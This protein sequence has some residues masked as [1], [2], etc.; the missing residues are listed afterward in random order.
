M[1]IASWA[2]QSIAQSSSFRRSTCQS[3]RSRHC[4]G[5]APNRSAFSARS[6]TGE[7]GQR[8]SELRVWIDP[9]HNAVLTSEQGLDLVPSRG[10][11]NTPILPVYPPAADDLPAARFARAA[12]ARNPQRS[13]LVVDEVRSLTADIRSSTTLEPGEYRSRDPADHVLLAPDTYLLVRRASTRP[14]LEVHDGELIDAELTTIARKTLWHES[15][16]SAE[17]L[18]LAAREQA[19]EALY[20]KLAAT[21]EEAYEVPLDPTIVRDRLLA[22][23]EH[24]NEQLLIVTELPRR[25][26]PAW[27]RQA[28]RE[29]RERGVECI[30]RD[31]TKPKGT[32][33]PRPRLSGCG[34]LAVR[35]N[36]R[37]LAHCDARLLGGGWTLD[38]LTSQ[39][40]LELHEPSAVRRLLDR[41][42]VDASSRPR[43]KPTAR[44][45]D[46]IAAEGMRKALA[47]L[48]GELPLDVPVAIEDSDMTSFFEQVER[49]GCR[50]DNQAH[51][52]RIADGIVWERLLYATCQ[53]L[54]DKH[55]QL[56]LEDMRR[57][58]PVGNIDLDD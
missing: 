8:V 20:A 29:A 15:G 5:C 46:D 25:A 36:A 30:T 4:S 34:I 26:W 16:L 11:P 48:R 13:R 41:L 32:E 57:Q 12:S 49:T 2:A 10:Y 14:M 23:L 6:C 44:P 28:H 3:R 58:P 17:R 52:K 38:T 7:H 39:A 50:P 54:A 1:P 19:H 9:A 53:A 42:Q 37:A 55:P 22:L 21:R 51:L 24:A 40:C 31:N 18:T 47:E 43:T 35:D 45:L 56:V 27:L 33:P